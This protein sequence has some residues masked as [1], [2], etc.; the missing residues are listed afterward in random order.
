MIWLSIA[1]CFLLLSTGNI[2][3]CSS[4]VYFG[5]DASAPVRSGIKAGLY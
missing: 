5:H 4:F 1:V 2:P 3:I